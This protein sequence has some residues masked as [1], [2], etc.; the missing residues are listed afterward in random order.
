M[1]DIRRLEH[2]C[3]KL[4]QQVKILMQEV[5]ELKG[6][7]NFVARVDS[8][9]LEQDIPEKDPSPSSVVAKLSSDITHHKGLIA[10]LSAEVEK[11]AKAIPRQQALLD[12]LNLK[13]EILEVKTTT[14]AYVWKVNEIRRRYQEA[15]DGKTSSL[16]SPPFYTSPHGYRLCLRA[17]LNG[18][19]SGKGTHVSLFV[20]IMK[21]EF[22]DLLSWPFRHRVT[23][24]LLNQE[25]PTEPRT[26]KT[27]R[28]I[29]NPESSSFR[30]PKD[31][32]NVAS[33][34]PE[35]VPSSVLHDP[36]FVKNDVLYIKVKLDSQTTSDI[37]GPDQVTY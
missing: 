12:E 20:V 17:Y 1:Q 23:L 14:G 18:D 37:T 10:H 30:K 5:H 16:Y 32:F 7:T 2:H 24:S 4:D 13:I 25:T 9:G 35:F 34:F 29:P 21:G 33:G 22:D 28:F 15:K 27:Q 31:A 8:S 26:S 11:L 6:E 36:A 3:M 19:G